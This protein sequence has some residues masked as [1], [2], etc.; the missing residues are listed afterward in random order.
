MKLKKRFITIF[1]GLTILSILIF[2][3]ST[4]EVAVTSHPGYDDA[5]LCVIA[6]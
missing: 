4:T 5:G 3:S 2:G 6:Y 1:A